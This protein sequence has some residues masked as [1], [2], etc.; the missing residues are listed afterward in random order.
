M[1]ELLPLPCQDKSSEWTDEYVTEQ[2]YDCTCATMKAR[3]FCPTQ[4]D[5]SYPTWEPRAVS[6]GECGIKRREDLVGAP[7]PPNSKILLYGNSHLRQVMEAIMCIYEDHIESKVVTL[8][9]SWVDTPVARDMQCRGC[10]YSDD[11]NWVSPLQQ[12]LWDHQCFAE[13]D[14]CICYD[15]RGEYTFGNGAV[16]HF[17]FSG[18]Q[19]GKGLADARREHGM[20]DLSSYDAVFVNPGND[21]PITAEKAIEMVLE[22]QAAGT[23]VFW[24]STFFRGSGIS[25]WSENQ[26]ARFYKAGALYVDI[27]C[28]ARGMNSWTRG[29]VEGVN[30]SHFCMPGP[31]NEIALLL[32]QIV[33]AVVEET[34]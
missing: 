17:K 8:G 23:Q 30:D 27:E 24:L 6:N 29:G 31:S 16:V 22:L 25:K 34:K 21:P 5:A 26:R 4:I 14:I 19:E 32:L 15:D 7:L 1:Q 28:M 11:P 2:L 13:S 9:P 12:S 18:N 20:E 10:S 3:Y 33:W